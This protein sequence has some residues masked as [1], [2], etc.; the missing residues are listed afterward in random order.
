MSNG[1]GGE[2]EADN[3]FI[4]VSAHR[5][6]RLRLRCV[7][8]CAITDQLFHIYLDNIGHSS[9]MTTR[10]SSATRANDDDIVYFFVT[11]VR[12]PPP[13][14]LLLLLLLLLHTTF[15]YY[16]HRTEGRDRDRDSP[17]GLIY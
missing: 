1:E 6:Q 12:P 5:R 7:E 10:L 17:N 8:R 14:H 4:G 9:S 11:I 13:P 15:E 3:Y 16:V 2:A